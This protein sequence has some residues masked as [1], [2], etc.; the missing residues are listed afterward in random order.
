MKFRCT[1]NMDNAAF[2]E[3]ATELERLLR[4]V[5]EAVSEERT[6]GVLTDYNGNKAGEWSIR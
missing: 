4:E 5:A 3:D 2:E 1:I 6:A